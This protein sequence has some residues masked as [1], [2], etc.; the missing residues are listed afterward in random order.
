MRGSELWHS[1]RFGACR[2]EMQ[3]TIFLAGSHFS[4]RLSGFGVLQPED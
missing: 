1:W 3:E 2:C 4:C